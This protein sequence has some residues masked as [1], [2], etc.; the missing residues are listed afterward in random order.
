MCT[1]FFYKTYNSRLF[2]GKNKVIAYALGRTVEDE[3]A[4]NI[5]KI[6]EKLIN[7]VGILFTNKSKEEV[8][9]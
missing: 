7:E 8:L 4:E 9:E 5:H 2:F 3:M 6:S 1:T